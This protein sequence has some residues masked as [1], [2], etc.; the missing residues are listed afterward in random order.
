M[1]HIV[2]ACAFVAGC[3]VALAG[4]LLG[5]IAAAASH[6]ATTTAWLSAILLALL[7][8]SG[9]LYVALFGARTRWSRRRR[10]IA[11]VLLL[12]P[13]LLSL[14]MMFLSGHPEWQRVL[15]PV[16]LAALALA[17]LAVWP[18]WPLRQSNNSGS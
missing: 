5:M 8:A 6:G 13:T 17:A 18:A 7:A 11:G 3:A 2:R 12:F 1:H 16:P 10:C 9:F 4:A 15:V 14:Y